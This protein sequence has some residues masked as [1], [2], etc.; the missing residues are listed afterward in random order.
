MEGQFGKS[1][2]AKGCLTDIVLSDRSER[3]P[4]WLSQGLFWS[5]LWVAHLLSGPDCLAALGRT[6]QWAVG[7]E[8]HTG[9]RG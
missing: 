1:Q 3:L 4:L 8:S 7:V 6:A 2:E 9:S 5:P